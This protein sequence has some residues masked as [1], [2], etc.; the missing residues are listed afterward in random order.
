MNQRIQVH[1]TE[2]HDLSQN[3]VQEKPFLKNQRHRQLHSL[4]WPLEGFSIFCCCTK[5]PWSGTLIRG[6]VVKIDTTVGA[7]FS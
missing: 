5:F 2:C 1:S 3:S 6:E 4:E 7:T